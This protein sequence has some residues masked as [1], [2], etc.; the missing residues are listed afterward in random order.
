MAEMMKRGMIIEIDHMP[1]RAY[2]R[3]FQILSEHGYPAVGSHGG[4]NR[5]KLYEL[6]GV[7]KVD[8]GACSDPAQPGGRVA[9]LERRV[10][11]MA[12]A[13]VFEAIGFGFDLNGF[14]GAPGPRFGDK[15]VCAG[16]QENP[17]TYPFTSYDGQVSF[18]EPA[19]G[20]RAIDFNTEG[21]AHIGLLPELIED[22][23]LDGV[24]DAQL[25]PLFKSAE[26]YLRMWERAIAR[27]AALGE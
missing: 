17:V 8:F 26:G 16:A 25:E 22:V 3:A 14:A 4:D 11:Q 24:T 20:E 27:S 10:G 19:V 1:R 9:D 6:G 2:E 13:G 15:S 5:G 23:R 7:S 18:T 12:D 21:L